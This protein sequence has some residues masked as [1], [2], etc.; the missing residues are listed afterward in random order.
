MKRIRPLPA[1]RQVTVAHT[2]RIFIDHSSIEIFT[3]EG[4]TVFTGRF[5]LEG[6]WTLAIQGT[7]TYCDLKNLEMVI[8]KEY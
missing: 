1:V 7:A 3:D 5:F 2:L 8:K 6:E 4:L